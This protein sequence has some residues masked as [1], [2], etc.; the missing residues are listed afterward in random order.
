MSNFDK[1]VHGKD[2]YENIKVNAIEKDK[3]NKEPFRS[4]QNIS[5]KTLIGASIISAFKKFFSSFFSS[6]NQIDLINKQKEL[7]EDIRTFRDLLKILTDMDLSHEPEFAQKLS[8]AWH[9]LLDDSQIIISNTPETSHALEQLKKFITEVDNFPPGEDHTLGYY[10]TEYAGKE[11]IPF[12][13]MDTL[14]DLHNAAK[15][16]SH[17]TLFKWIGDLNQILDLLAPSKPE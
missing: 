16:S 4:P 10:F 14:L 15:I 6:E 2:P 9:R 17:A 13:F 12:P 1:S 5:P 11:W 3:Q 8:D 7:I